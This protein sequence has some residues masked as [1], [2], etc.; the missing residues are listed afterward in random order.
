MKFVDSRHPP[1]LVGFA[2]AGVPRFYEFTDALEVTRVPHGSHLMRAH[3]CNVVNNCNRIFN[4][5]PPECEWLWLLGDDHAWDPGL[6]MQLLDHDVDLVVPLTPRRMPPWLPV[7]YARYKPSPDGSPTTETRT[8]SWQ[9]L[10]DAMPYNNGLLPI[11][12]SGD[13]GMLVRR[14][15]WEAIEKAYGFPWYRVGTTGPDSVAGDL[16]FTWKAA[17]LGFDCNVDTRA[18]MEHLVTAGM[19]PRLDPVTGRLTITAHIFD[20]HLTAITTEGTQDLPMIVQPRPAVDVI[21]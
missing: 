10:A 5:M 20:R 16:D 11:A 3:S 12:A 6:L 15:V 14:H 17:Q 2:T 4:E 8:Y 21:V 18:Y 7:V 13:A 19:G 1:G 9:E